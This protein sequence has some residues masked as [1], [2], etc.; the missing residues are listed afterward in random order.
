[1]VKMGAEF[2]H[3]GRRLPLVPLSGGTGA[4]QADLKSNE[5]S[6]RGSKRASIISMAACRKTP[7]AAAKWMWKAQRKEDNGRLWNLSEKILIAS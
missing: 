1:M 6:G 4:F 5:G 2:W 3:Q 7:L